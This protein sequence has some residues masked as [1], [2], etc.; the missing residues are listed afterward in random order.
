MIRRVKKPQP[1]GAI[2]LAANRRNMERI[3]A[4]CI[5]RTALREAMRM[6]RALQSEI[7]E[8]RS[9]AGR[10]S[11]LFPARPMK[12]NLKAPKR[13]GRETF[14]VAVGDPQIMERP[15]GH[16][17]DSRTTTLKRRVKTLDMLVAEVHPDAL[18]SAVHCEARFA[19]GEVRYSISL[20]DLLM[21]P[22]SDAV[23]RIERHIAPAMAASL[24][25][26]LR[27]R[28]G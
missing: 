7:D 9:I 20:A 27:K 21:M 16:D 18:H 1:A 22:R 19:D 4:L 8:A 23:A 24:V 17:D 3:N 10:M 26:H 12:I 11:V 2:R 15:I 25:D 14:D 28:G 5:E 6:D 13:G